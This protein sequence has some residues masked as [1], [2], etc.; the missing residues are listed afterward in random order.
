MAEKPIWILNLNEIVASI[1]FSRDAAVN[2]A[3]HSAIRSHMTAGRAMAKGFSEVADGHPAFDRYKSDAAAAEARGLLPVFV[4]D[5]LPDLESTDVIDHVCDWLAEVHVHSPRH[6]RAILSRR[7]SFVQMID[8]AERWHDAQRRAAERL[9]NRA[10]ERDDIGAP[11][12]MDLD[13]EWLGWR[14]VFLES[15]AARDAEGFAMG[16]CVGRGYYDDLGKS[17]G[18]FSLRDPDG[19]PHVTVEMNRLSTKQAKCRGNSSVTD[20]FRPL[21]DRMATV[22]GVRLCIHGNPTQPVDDG[23]HVIDGGAAAGTMTYYVANGVMNRSGGPA[24]V[25]AGGAIYYE[26]GVK[27]KV[28]FTRPVDRPALYSK[29]KNG[30]ETPCDVAGKRI[31]LRLAHEHRPAHFRHVPPAVDAPAPE[32]RP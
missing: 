7:M 6:H 22:I 13:G 20:R 3:V 29:F 15:N 10:I 8:A 1:E 12:V 26:R 2:A 21:V 31:P 14:W 25:G 32:V 4:T 27:M 16:H 11:T 30:R 18:V 23:V 9:R 17:A 24:I 28:I 19:A 5:F